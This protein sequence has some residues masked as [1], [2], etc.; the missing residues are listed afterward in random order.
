MTCFSFYPSKNLGCYGD[1]G[2][3]TTNDKKHMSGC[4]N[5][6]ITGRKRYYHSIKVLIADWMNCGVN[7]HVKNAVS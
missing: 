1:G 5:Y 2:A 7:S 4:Y 3:I 6:V